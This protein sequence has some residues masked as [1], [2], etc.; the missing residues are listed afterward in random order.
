MYQSIF[1]V[2]VCEKRHVYSH[3]AE[4]GVFQLDGM[5]TLPPSSHSRVHIQTEEG[6]DRETTKAD[7]RAAM[8]QEWVY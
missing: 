8:A 5:E 3:Y 4:D 6:R 2:S 7:Q 1:G